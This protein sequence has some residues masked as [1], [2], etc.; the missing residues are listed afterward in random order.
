[1]KQPKRRYRKTK[2][3]QGRRALESAD[4]KDSNW[5]KR[6]KNPTKS[7]SNPDGTSST[8]RMAYAEIGDPNAKEKDKRFLVS[9]V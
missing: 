2:K 9:L 1:M 4:V 5:L 6:A 8:H 7:I 3:D